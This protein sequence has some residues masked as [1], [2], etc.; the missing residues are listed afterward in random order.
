[1]RSDLVHQNTI[2]IQTRTQNLKSITG[3]RLIPFIRWGVSNRGSGKLG[4]SGSPC[5]EILVWGESGSILDTTVSKKI[6][7]L[8]PQTSISDHGEPEHPPCHPGGGGRGW[9]RNARGSTLFLCKPIKMSSFPQFLV[10]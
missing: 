8:S 6:E 2:F 4:F 1:M 9:V 5:S 7:P 10:Y 3:Y